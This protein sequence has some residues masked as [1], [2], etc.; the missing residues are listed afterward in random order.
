[1]VILT[2][3][4]DLLDWLLPRA[5]KFPAVQ[6]FVFTRRLTDAAFD[7]VE[8][9]YLANA[10]K[11]ETRLAHLQIA[12]AKLDTLR[13]YLRIAHRRDYLTDGQYGH[14]SKMVAEIGRLLGGWMKQTQK[15]LENPSI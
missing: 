3:T 7:T 13:L 8:A 11:G 12:D 14:V 4:Y 9:L 15:Q 6:R 1:M 2:R 10:H 5:E